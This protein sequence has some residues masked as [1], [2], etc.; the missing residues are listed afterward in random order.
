MRDSDFETALTRLSGV[1]EVR[2]Q[3]LVI[4]ESCS[5]GWTAKLCT[6]RAGCSNWFEASITTYG[7]IAKQTLLGVSADTL[8]RHGAVSKEVVLEMVSGAL[9][10]VMLA[11]VAVAVTGIAG[12]SGG[13]P[14]KPVGTVWIAWAQRDDK[15]LA[16]CLHFDGVR[17]AV[18][19]AAAQRALVGLLDYLN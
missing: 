1:L 13:T 2:G 14:E 15:P 3:R 6:D 12:P 4:A 8:E 5:G 9:Q 10:R 19:L 17:E 11:D 16:Q 18:R 7:N